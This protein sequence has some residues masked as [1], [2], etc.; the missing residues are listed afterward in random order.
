MAYDNLVPDGES[1][2][3][4]EVPNDRFFASGDVHVIELFDPANSM[5]APL[6]KATTTVLFEPTISSHLQSPA[7]VRRPRRRSPKSSSA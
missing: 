1:I 2:A 5:F 3:G 6:A 7:K 4:T